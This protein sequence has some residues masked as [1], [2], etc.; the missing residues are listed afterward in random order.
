MK[1][2]EISSYPKS[3]NTWTRTL[4]RELLKGCTGTDVELPL[5]VHKEKSD[6]REM[7]K[8]VAL[9]GT[10]E[11]FLFYKSHVVNSPG[12]TPDCILYIYRHPLDVFLSSLNFLYHR[13]KNLPKKRNDE[14]FLNGRPKP[15]EQIVADGEMNF[16]FDRFCDDLGVSFYRDML[17]DKA[18]YFDHVFDA[19]ERDNS[20]VMRYEDLLEDT[21]SV[22]KAKA[23]E[24]TGYD[25]VDTKIN[26]AKV[27][28][29]TVNNS[30]RKNFFWKA[31]KGTRFEMLSDEQ[32]AAFETK[33]KDKL[34][35]L[36]Y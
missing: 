16:Y 29:D 26:F 5:S 27:D 7:G 34:A 32:I 4:V 21:D 31:T 19:M 15:V 30:K 33:Y 35:R 10:Q 1:L 25:F 22:I 24:A 11:T 36:G 9:P 20:V 8:P 2:I 12:L 3:G 13:S 18:N 6:I 14:L 28:A 17:G 23:S